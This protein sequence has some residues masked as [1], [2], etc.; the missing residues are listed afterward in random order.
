MQWQPEKY[1]PVLKLMARR[2]YLD[3]RFRRRFDS[4]D[5]VQKTLLKA[6]ET[7]AQCR[8]DQEPQRVRRKAK[9]PVFLIRDD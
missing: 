3:R 2:L 9:I 1:R 5:L 8:G 7:S 6:H 4:S